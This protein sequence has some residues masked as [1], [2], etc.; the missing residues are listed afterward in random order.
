[1]LGPRAED[2]YVVA[3]GLSEG[4]LVVVNGAFKIDSAM[5]I[6]ARPSMMSPEGGV[7]PPS[8]DHGSPRQSVV[9]PATVERFESPGGFQSGLGEAYRHYLEA[10]DALARDNS[11]EARTA[12]AKLVGALEGISMEGLEE[13]EAHATWMRLSKLMLTAAAVIESATEL[14]AARTELPALT[15]ALADAVRAFGLSEGIAVLRFH[16]PMASD[17]RGADWL[18]SAVDTAN[19]YYGAAMYRCGE[20]VETIADGENR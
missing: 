11:A 10:T 19:P 1:V 7:A 18:Q 17:G 14:D 8:H 20:A 5:Q 13:G 9:E 6:Q 12:G 15:G 3:S 2:H 16:C 4:E